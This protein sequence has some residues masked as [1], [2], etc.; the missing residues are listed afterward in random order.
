[1]KQYTDI[2]V[3]LDRSGSMTSIKESMET[4]FNTFVNEHKAIP[5]TRISLIQFDD[6]DPQEIVYL[7]V[8]V[9]HVEKLVLR[10]RGNTPLLDA[11]CDA[12]DKTGSRLANIPSDRRPDQVLFVVITD[13]AENASR[14][15]QRS[16]VKHRVTHQQDHYKWQFVYLGANQDAIQEAQSFGI[17]R[18]WAIN[19]A[20]TEAGVRGWTRSLTSNTVAYAT[21]VDRT[22]PMAGF[23]SEQRKE[24]EAE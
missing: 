18:D 16:D 17:S 14:R 12:I 3:L 1:M 20:A 7:G 10:P 4:A 11:F 9:T 2:T 5:T 19:Y 15:Y 24:A 21:N 23:T 8:P 13:G 6:T 22:A